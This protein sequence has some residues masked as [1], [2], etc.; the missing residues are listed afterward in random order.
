MNIIILSWITIAHIIYILRI[1]ISK[2]DDEL[3]YLYASCLIWPFLI[4]DL[5]AL[6]VTYLLDCTSWLGEYV[7]E[8]Y[9]DFMLFYSYMESNTLKD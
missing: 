1:A 8:I 9:W 6:M 7:L 5:F 4:A 3:N 2:K